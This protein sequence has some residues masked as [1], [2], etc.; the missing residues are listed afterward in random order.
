[1]KELGYFEKMKKGKASGKDGL[2]CASSRQTAQ[3]W[4]LEYNKKLKNFYEM[5]H[6]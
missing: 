6:E 2:D 1:M 5:E 4:R 3:K